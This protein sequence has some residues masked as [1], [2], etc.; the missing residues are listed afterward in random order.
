[1]TE[2]LKQ[3]MEDVTD[4]DR[5]WAALAW[6]P[7]GP[8]WPIVAV[9]VLLLDETKNRPYVRYHAILSLATGVALIPLSIVTCGVG[10]LLYLAFFFWAYQAYVGQ[11]VN[12]PFITD[13]VRRQGWTS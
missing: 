2:E 13:W 7:I 4:N 9:L 12:I 8:L 6:L 5:L 1:M 11:E 3:M 10:A